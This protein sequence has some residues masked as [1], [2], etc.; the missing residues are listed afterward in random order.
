MPFSISRRRVI[1]AS[2]AVSLC[3][4]ISPAAI[5]DDRLTAART[6]LAPT[7]TLRVILFPLPIIATRDATGTLQGVAADIS[8]ELG[9]RLG[10]PV[11]LIP[12][13]DPAS[14]VEQV[15]TQGAD[16]TFLVNLP[17]RAALI[18]FGPAY[19]SLETTYLVSANSRIADLADIDQ[20]GRRILVPQNSDLSATLARTLKQAV[21]IQNPIGAMKLAAEK[22][23]AGDADAYTDFH[24]LL[25]LLQPSVPGSRILTGS[26]M[27]TDLSVATRKGSDSGAAYVAE[28]VK[29]MK[30]S[31][32]IA[33]AIARAGL[34]GA[35]VPR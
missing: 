28:A 17:A 22:L 4:G 33:D 21:L 10:V 18:D 24:H 7:G 30:S 12:A 20:P 26:I 25:S 19:V 27:A 23:V 29:E 3:Y 16:L 14:T 2:V 5:A 11:E 34:K 35:L 15:R 13:A 32:F 1:L 9:R 31:G 8:R 6:E